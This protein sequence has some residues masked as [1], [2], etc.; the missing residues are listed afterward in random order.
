[1]TL[2]IESVRSADYL[3]SVSYQNSIVMTATKIMKIFKDVFLRYATYIMIHIQQ[4]AEI[5]MYLPNISCPKPLLLKL[6]GS[7][8]KSPSC[9]VHIYLL[10]DVSFY[11]ICLTKMKCA[12]TMLPRIP[13]LKGGVME[14]GDIC[15]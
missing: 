9:S 2:T 3:E 7:R 14:L 8:Y 15:P 12:E 6:S 13:S 5:S 4:F 11:E 1:M 10:S